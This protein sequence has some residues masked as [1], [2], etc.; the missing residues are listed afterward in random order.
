MLERSGIECPMLTGGS[1]GTYNIDAA[2]DG[3]TELQPGSFVFMV[4][5]VAMPAVG[6]ARRDGQ[7]A[8]A[9]T[10]MDPATQRAFNLA[11]GSIPARS[12]VPLDGLDDCARQAAVDLQAAARH[13]ALLNRFAASASESA[14]D[15]I[16]A[17]V[18]Q[19][20]A[21]DETPA[22]AAVRLRHVLRSP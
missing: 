6:S 5:M 7:Q 19:F 12:D 17:V 16:Y 11:K 22:A 4:D 21:S 3:V 20:I 14:R 9:R 1:T 8:L 18:T 13:H 2:I 10:L 15:A